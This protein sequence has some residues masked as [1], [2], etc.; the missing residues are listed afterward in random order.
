MDY[1]RG[2]SL[3]V[4]VSACHVTTQAELTRPGTTER[5]PHPE[6][7]VARRPTLVLTDAGTLRFIEPLE[8]PTEEIVT[9][10]T[11][12][13]VTT[14]PNLATFVVGVIA[15]SIGGVLTVK[16]VTSDDR[17]NPS[18][19]VGITGLVV[20][21]P[22]AIGPWIGRDVALRPATER[23]PTRRPGPSEPCG[24]RALV[25]RSATLTVRGIEVHGAID[26][27]GTF[28]V[29]PY[30]LVDAFD[31]KAIP[32]LDISA[33][34]EADAGARTIATVIE[35]GALAGKAPAFLASASFD[36]TIQPMRLVPGIVAGTLRASL[37]SIPTGPALRIVLPLK[38]DGP[39]EA[40]ALRGQLT[41]TTKA[42][43]GRMIYIGHVAKGAAISRELIVPVTKE[44][45]ATIRGATIEM[46]VEL[47]DAHGTAP[48]TPIRFRGAVLGDAPR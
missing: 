3:A 10:T 34:V 28:A 19:Y 4:M 48:A 1:V 5:I 25:A 44:A 13:E 33:I 2:L 42:I 20:G 47:R 23:A 22:L 7:A 24:S 36:A 43:D 45:A 11:T 26:R 6:G 17:G 9:T 8:C 14:E 30:E 16:G 46:S 12:V 32:A 31:T 15:T 41:S 40:W 29:S 37:T 35:G 39:G 27:D 38:N 21:L 18:T